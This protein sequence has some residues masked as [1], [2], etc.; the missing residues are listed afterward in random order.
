MTNTYLYSLKLYITR[1]CP[2]DCSYCFVKNKKRW[3]EM[4]FITAKKSIDFFLNT[5]WVKKNIYFMW[6]EPFSNV[7]LLI[8]IIKYILTFNLDITIIIVTSGIYQIEKRVLSLLKNNRQIKISFSIDWLKRH[9]NYNRKLIN[10]GLTWDKIV[11]NINSI[12]KNYQF[13]GTITIPWDDKIV[14][15][16]FFSFVN[17]HRNLKFNFIHIWDVEWNFWPYST[18]I[19]YIKNIVQILNYIYWHYCK[20]QYIYLA[21]FNRFLVRNHHFFYEK[22][23]FFKNNLRM[24][25]VDYN[26]DFGS[27]MWSIND[28]KFVYF[29]IENVSIKNTDIFLKKILNED[30]NS[31]K[32]L[33]NHNIKDLNYI[34]YKVFDKYKYKFWNDY[35]KKILVDRLYI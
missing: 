18:K 13:C 33:K 12:A 30:M 31:M 5:P 10:W 34:V 11:N 22:D 9:H 1:Y 2:L 7:N 27:V 14:N 15:D 26:G 28:K 35:L 20:W 29:N 17:L 16:L 8:D 4:D 21:F 19:L 23:T 25:D 3:N 24:V 6:G 32:V